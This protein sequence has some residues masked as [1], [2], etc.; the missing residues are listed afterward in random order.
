M[1]LY[2]VHV[3]R[4]QWVSKG[5][6]RGVHAHWVGESAYSPGRQLLSVGMSVLNSG[7]V[8]PCCITASKW[9]HLMVSLL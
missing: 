2:G 8:P 5:G 9:A 6:S 3:V 4:R 7:S 1:T